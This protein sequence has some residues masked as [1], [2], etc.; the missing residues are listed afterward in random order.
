[1]IGYFA[2]RRYAG[3]APLVGPLMKADLKFLPVFA[4]LRA[5]IRFIP[6]A[7]NRG[8]DQRPA[9]SRW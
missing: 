3:K 5:H 1:M 2:G 9:S 8:R 4:P 6:P 7:A